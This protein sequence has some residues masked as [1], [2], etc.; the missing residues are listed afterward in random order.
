MSISASPLGEQQ[1]RYD[2]SDVYIYNDEE[3]NDTVLRRPAIDRKQAHDLSHKSYQQM[4]P[5]Y[6]AASKALFVNHN[7]FPFAFNEQTRA[8]RTF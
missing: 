8:Q 2:T 5:H 3:M 6:L 1:T 4:K 7:Y